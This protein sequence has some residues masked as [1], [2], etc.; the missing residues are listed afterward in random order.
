MIEVPGHKLTLNNGRVEL[1][2]NVGKPKDF[3]IGWEQFIVQAQKFGRATVTIVA[4]VPRYP[5]LL[6]AVT[7]ESIVLRALAGKSLE[8]T[9]AVAVTV[10]NA[11]AYGDFGMKYFDK[12]SFMNMGVNKGVCVELVD[13]KSR[14][15]ATSPKPLKK[16]GTRSDL[17][18]VGKTPSQKKVA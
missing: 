13:S 11:G 16:E 6:A 7:G 3:Y 4:D 2:R 1:A 9:E 8:L 15:S 12:A 5:V 14:M 17:K 18:F 10:C